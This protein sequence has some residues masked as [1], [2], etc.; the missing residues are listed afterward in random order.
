MKSTLD[1]IVQNDEETTVIHDKFDLPI[2]KISFMF[3]TAH[4]N[5]KLD[6]VKPLVIYKASR[7]HTWRVKRGVS[8][9][10]HMR[11]EADNI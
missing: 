6:N 3:D 11:C 4:C 10:H 2:V 1:P 5:T 9:L 8:I 7:L